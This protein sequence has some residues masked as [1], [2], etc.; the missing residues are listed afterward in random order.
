[1]LIVVLNYATYIVWFLGNT[2]NFI[3]I[4]LLDAHVILGI[5]S[6]LF[7]IILIIIIQ[8]WFHRRSEEYTRCMEDKQKLELKLEET[9][10]RSQEESQQLKQEIQNSQK[11]K[12]EI[13]KLMQTSEKLRLSFEKEKD[14]KLCGICQDHEKTI[15]CCHVNICVCVNNVWN[16]RN[17]K[18]AQFVVR[19]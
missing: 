8:R 12:Q 7:V 15:V 4:T 6:A 9:V 17:G 13:Q 19:V 5:A 11:L 2:L 1:M 18:N 14:E 10:S 3:T 16:I